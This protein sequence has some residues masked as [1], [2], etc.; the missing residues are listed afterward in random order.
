MRHVLRDAGE[1]VRSISGAEQ[2]GIKQ[3]NALFPTNARRT[4][5]LPGN[6]KADVWTVTHV[7]S[8]SALG[9]W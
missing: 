4:V 8:S 7:S 5:V 6:K 2:P 1:A 3:T 9:S